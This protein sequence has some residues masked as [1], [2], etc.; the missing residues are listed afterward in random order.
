MA[1]LYTAMITRTT[2]PGFKTFNLK[3]GIL[4]AP[5]LYIYAEM[6]KGPKNL[7]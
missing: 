4:G 6:K 2:P 5:A 3:I 1:T 7:M